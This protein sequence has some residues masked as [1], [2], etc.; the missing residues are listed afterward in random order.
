M[1]PYE[2]LDP[3]RRNIRLITLLPVKLDETIACHIETVSLDDLPVYTTLSYVWGNAADTRPIFL[4]NHSHEAT[5]N[6][7]CA[8]RNLG[9]KLTEPQKFWID[10]LCVNQQNISERSQQVSLM[11]AIY[12]QSNNA[13]VWLGEWDPVTLSNHSAIQETYQLLK[14]LASNKHCQHIP[15]LW[16]PDASYNKSRS[17][18]CSIIE[19]LVSRSYWN[20][21]WIVQ[22]FILP[23]QADI[24]CGPF[25]VNRNLLLKAGENY[26]E[27]FNSCCNATLP[28]NKDLG[29]ILKVM[30]ALD[31]KLIGLAFLSRVEA[32]EETMNRRTLWELLCTFRATEASD[33]R[34]KIFAFLGLA[35]VQ[36]GSQP[37]LADYTMTTHD[38]YTTVGCRMF[39]ESQSLL[40][41]TQ[42][43][44]KASYPQLPS[45]VP[46]WTA[47][48]MN[49]FMFADWC[50]RAN[51]FF[52]ASG[53]IP[54]FATISD[55]SKILILCGI[56]I[57][58]VKDAIFPDVR[59]VVPTL[60]LWEERVLASS[61]VNG[62][63]SQKISSTRLRQ[64]L[65]RTAIGDQISTLSEKPPQEGVSHLQSRRV[66]TEDLYVLVRF[67]AQVK[68]S[69]DLET[70]L[71]HPNPL[72][73]ELC[74]TLLGTQ[75]RGDKL[76]IL[77]QNLIGLGPPAAQRGDEVWIMPSSPVP[78]VLR[79]LKTDASDEREPSG[80]HQ[81][82]GH[83]YV[84]GV[85]D[86][87][88]T[89]NW[90]MKLELVL[91]V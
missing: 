62:S 17:E 33:H 75:A 9:R 15:L 5:V 82:V 3:E 19:Y 26:R 67:M 1:Y 72:Y 25:S 78:I 41:L 73:R 20:R 84:D 81:L 53:S 79:P 32:E 12:K 11:K 29:D 6:L 59:S 18:V 61:L 52:S 86:G 80:L 88:A 48:E 57:G 21:A 36:P 14:D 34:D 27:H 55:N 56:K 47:I 31:R 46:D 39:N 58:I 90:E 44:R 35:K 77:D 2:P 10:A 24:V 69:V 40:L 8:L 87:E 13:I 83:C 30:A 4:D 54:V 70:I 28:L 68:A 22:E 49:D 64:S 71:G 85:M 42:C 60:A 76:L 45:W 43:T 37:L 16:D 50:H 89:E 63:T 66:R 65:M 7:E 74:N 23:N 91:I 51:H 38:L